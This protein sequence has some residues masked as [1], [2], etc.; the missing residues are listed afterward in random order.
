MIGQLPLMIITDILNKW[1]TK[2]RAR[3]GAEAG[4]TEMGNYVF[5]IMFCILGQPVC[6][7]LYYQAWY[8]TYG[9]GAGKA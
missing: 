2:W 7:L 9:A 5:W 4:G 6:L 3:R 8:V 1:E